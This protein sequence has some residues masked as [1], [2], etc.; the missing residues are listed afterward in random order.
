MKSEQEIR[1]EAIQ[2]ERS[3]ILARL[4]EAASMCGDSEGE[5]H[6][7][8]VLEAQVGMIRQGLHERNLD[9]VPDFM[10]DITRFHQLFGLEY[11]GKPRMLP[12]G[13]FDFRYKFMHEEIE[14]YREE[15]EKLADAVTRQDDRDILNALE[16]QLDGL[17]DE[18]YVV[19]GTAYLQFGPKIFN[20]AW[21]RVHAANMKKERAE[22][23]EDARSHRDT[24]FDVVK[25]EGW[26]C[27]DHRDLVEDHA[28][29]RY[30]HPGAVTNE[31]RSDTQIAR[32]EKQEA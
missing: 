20:E 3:D 28:H 17:V 27:P 18:V 6:A 24:A 32:D 13:L 2:T 30:R 22:A 16:K 8:T 26:E 10:G 9:E 12:P 19:L 15:Q 29:K 11:S 23:D 21:R 25:P 31:T 4:E 1:D 5:H 7:K 14:E